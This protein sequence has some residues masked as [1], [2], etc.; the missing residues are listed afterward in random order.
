MKLNT[1]HPEAI[2]Q[3]LEENRDLDINNALV[4]ETTVFCN[5]VTLDLKPHNGAILLRM[6]ETITGIGVPVAIS[7]MSL[8]EATD[9]ALTLCAQLPEDKIDAVI[10]ILKD[11]K[12]QKCSDADNTHPAANLH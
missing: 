7:E 5:L 12:K 10:S 9:L 6:R 4:L 8:F 11:V 3:K 1:F 2:A